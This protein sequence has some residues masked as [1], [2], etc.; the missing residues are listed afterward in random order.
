MKVDISPRT[1]SRI[2]AILSEEFSAHNERG[3]AAATKGDGCPQDN[4]I[5]A[6]IAAAIRAYQ[7]GVSD[8]Y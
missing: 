1:R 2:E 6:A 8:T 7:L 3:Y 4:I 5:K